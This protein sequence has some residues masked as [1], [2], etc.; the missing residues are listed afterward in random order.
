MS[1]YTIF[2]NTDIPI[3]S[4]ESPEFYKYYFNKI[5]RNDI[6]AKLTQEF[7]ED[8]RSKKDHGLQRQYANASAYANAM[9]IHYDNNGVPRNPRDRRIPSPMKSRIGGSKKSKNSKKVKKANKSKKSKK[10]KK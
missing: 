4:H 10:S 5:N 9:A 7:D 8:Y 1:L 6:L 3:T 2:K